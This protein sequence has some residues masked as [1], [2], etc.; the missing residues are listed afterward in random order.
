[1]DFGVVLPLTE[2]LA[3]DPECISESGDLY[4]SGFKKRFVEGPFSVY[5]REVG[6]GRTY[7]RSLWE[8]VLRNEDITNSIRSRRML[9]ELE[10]P[11]KGQTRP[12]YASHLIT[13]LKIDDNGIVSGRYES[14]DTPRGHILSNL[15]GEKVL[16]GVSSRGEG[17][18][19][20]RNGSVFVDEDTFKLETYDVVLKPSAP[21]AFP[22]VQEILAQENQEKILETVRKTLK[23]DS[24]EKDNQA[25]GE[26]AESYLN[27][28]QLSSLA[29]EIVQEA[30]RLGTRRSVRM[31]DVFDQKTIL[32]KLEENTE[33]VTGLNSKI[34][35]LQEDLQTEKKSVTQLSEDLN[36]EKGRTEQLQE[37]LS[38]LE[39][40][41]TEMSE[42][43]GNAK[44]FIK[45]ALPIIQDYKNLEETVNNSADIEEVESLLD[46]NE[47][48]ENQLTEAEEIL[49]T[50]DLIESELGIPIETMYEQYNNAVKFIEESL[51]YLQKY[52]DVLQERDQFRAL[53]E[54][55]AGFCHESVKSGILDHAESS[56]A[57][58]DVKES[59]KKVN[60]LT[61]AK[62][63]VEASTGHKL[64]AS[65]DIS[66]PGPKSL[67]ENQA[68]V[69]NGTRKL[70][71]SGDRG[72]AMTQRMLGIG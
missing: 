63:I 13:G 37:S 40:K 32:R 52:S 65:K 70:H 67:E 64:P 44:R 62:A 72:V 2:A 57:S 59:L 34:S 8:K 31:T 53:S 51:P 54:D 21:G 20:N 69:V 14:L 28:S 35:K 33:T 24:S 58:D 41:N 48:M 27:D 23:L 39:E 66:L 60:D 68:K 49:E 42:Q 6:N 43:L 1:M 22:R 9:G 7:S 4:P 38:L 25:C 11:E 26:L 10:H 36:Q 55:L 29:S 5:D 46:E 30:A 12:W 47:L 16:L 3:I 56:G 61:T 17:S 19:V 50:V 18:L 15:L 45:E 71:E